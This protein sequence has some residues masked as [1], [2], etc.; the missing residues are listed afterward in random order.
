VTMS[1]AAQNG[2]VSRDNRLNDYVSLVG[3]TV[4]NA[5][6]W[7][8]RPVHFAVINSPIVNAYSAPNGYVL[9]TTGALAQIQ[10]E[11][12]LAGVLA[13]EVGHVVHE[14]GLAAVRRANLLK[15]GVTLASTNSS[16]AQ[17]GAVSDYLVD[18]LTKQAFDQPAGM[19]A[20]DS[21]IQYVIAAGYDPNG[22]V[23][24]LQRLAVVQT[25]GG[26]LFSTHPATADRIKRATANI[27]RSGYDGSGKRLDARFRQ[28]AVRSAPLTPR[29]MCENS[30]PD[31]YPGSAFRPRCRG[32]RVARRAHRLLCD[33]RAP[34]PHQACDFAGVQNHPG[35]DGC[36]E[37]AL[38]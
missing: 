35:G 27:A 3:M 22:Y 26:G 20:D 11:S 1:I 32:L 21:S 4:V 10:D 17:L 38:G 6:S 9:I 18:F 16:F 30:A 15:A 7:A 24:F 2:G 8:D 14:H 23:R 34:R 36:R 25:G 37:P 12:E 31:E 5:S 29:G 28:Y 33:A 19:E 13:H